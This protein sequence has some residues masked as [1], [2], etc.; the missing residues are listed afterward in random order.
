MADSTQSIEERLEYQKRLNAITNEIHAA[1]DTNEILLNLQGRILSLFDAERITIFVVDR[2]KRQLV[3][4]VKTGDEVQEIRVGLNKKSIAGFC[5]VTGRILNIADVY[6]DQALQRISPDLRFDRSWDERTGYQTRQ[7]LASP[8]V[9]ARQL[10]GVIQLLNKTHGTRF[11]RDDHAALMDI[12]KVLG[13]AFYKNQKLTQQTKPAKFDYLLTNNILSGNE[14]NQ[15]MSRARNSKR[16]VESVLMSDFKVSREDIGKAL[17]SHYRTRFI[18]FVDKMAIPG[19][20]LKGLKANFLKNNVFVPVGQSDGKIMV[21]MEN[22]D[23]LPARDAVKR[24]FP[25]RER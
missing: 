11:T 18:P 13:L 2:E 5:A 19:E 12:L 8:I 3:S 22:P 1:T 14:L 4:M 21:V 9:Q 6:D 7:V 23:Y 24:L 15:A 10:L 16:S 17:A 20:L 25:G